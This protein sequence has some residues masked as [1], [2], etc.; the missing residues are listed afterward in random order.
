MKIVNTTWRPDEFWK[1]GI[2]SLVPG[3][4]L[5]VVNGHRAA[6]EQLMAAIA[7]ADVLLGDST[8]ATKI[9]REIIFAARRLKF[10]QQPSVG[11]DAIDVAAC[12]E[13]GIPVA[14]T[15]GAND[16]GVAEHT[17]ML[18]LAC[19]KK[20]P[21]FNAKTHQ[22]EWLFSQAQG[23]GVFEIHGQI[24]GL[25]GAGRTAREV[26]KRLVP[27]G[28]RVLYYDIVRL[29]A[30]DEAAYRVAYAPWEEILRTANVVSLHLPLNAETK[31]FMNRERLALMKPD[32]I[33]INVGRGELVDEEA[34]AAALKDHRLGYAATDVYSQE[35]PPPDHPLFGLEN[36]ILTPHLAGATNESRARILSMAM[37]N[38]ARVIRG[39]APHWLIAG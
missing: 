35:P 23:I 12:G 15:P 36:V 10:I 32:A 1:A 28:A 38:V 9:T 8:S 21:L 11:Y 19:L 13:K 26:A 5:S 29:S 22:G 6:K 20:L 7:D 16:I 4:A 27:F 31:G 25:I 30:T 37:E 34:L 3:V 18:A 17:V 24:Y 14:N 33:L 39:E 2:E